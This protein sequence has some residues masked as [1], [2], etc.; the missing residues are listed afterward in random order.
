M[1]VFTS[2]SPS[3]PV[4]RTTL[5]YSETHGQEVFISSLSSFRLVLAAGLFLDYFTSITYHHLLLRGLGLIA[6]LF[7]GAPVMIESSQ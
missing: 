7:V 6:M 1:H 3:S 5:A 2:W 4:H